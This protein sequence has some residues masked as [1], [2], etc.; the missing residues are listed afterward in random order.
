[1]L[2]YT[3]G[4]MYLV[5]GSYTFDKDL[6]TDECVNNDQE[7]QIVSSGGSGSGNNNNND[8]GGDH[9]KI[10]RNARAAQLSK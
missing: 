3:V 7:L 8:G 5:A 6:C 1:M 2:L 10:P 9:A 4:T